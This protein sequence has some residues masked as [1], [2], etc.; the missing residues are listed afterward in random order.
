MF[1]FKLR[2]YISNIIQYYTNIII[3]QKDLCIEKVIN[4]ESYKTK[5]VSPW[6]R[7]KTLPN[8]TL[9]EAG[10]SLKKFLHTDRL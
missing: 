3:I 2:K 7:D 10:T 4:V 5:L 1:V 9:P 6:D 8:K